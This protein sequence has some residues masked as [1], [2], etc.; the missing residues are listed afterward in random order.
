[1]VPPG[2]TRPWAGLG[3]VGGSALLA[4][5]FGGLLALYLAFVVTP[6]NIVGGSPDYA[7]G[8]LDVRGLAYLLGIPTAATV[9]ATLAYLGVVLRRPSLLGVIGILA[10]V[11]CA[12]LVGWETAPI[13]RWWI[14]DLS[15][16]YVFG[17]TVVVTV[18]VVILTSIPISLSARLAFAATVP[19]RGGRVVATLALGAVSGLFVGM[20]VGGESAVLSQLQIMCPTAG[21]CP[22]GSVQ[23]AFVGGTFLGVVY[24]LVAGLLCGL[25]VAALPPWPRTPTPKREPT[26]PPADARP[27]SAET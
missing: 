27:P 8:G 3:R 26:F 21:P 12:G 2:E 6:S 10:G 23:D 9:A 11:V 15:P 24:G 7:N 13:A 17:P 5:V 25:L 14:G 18:V 16:Q 4:A 20:L 22:D 1:M 19:T